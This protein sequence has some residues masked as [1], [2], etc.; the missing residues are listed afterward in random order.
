M[1]DASLAWNT[2]V[3]AR[4]QTKT[5]KSKV[6]LYYFDE[7]AE[8]P[9][10]SESAGYGARHAAELPY[11]FRQLTEHNRPAPTQKDEALSEMLRTFWTNFAKTGDPN[12]TDLPKWPAYSDATPQMLHIE[13][14]NTK[15]GPMINENGLK[16]LDEYFTWRRTDEVTAAPH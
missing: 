12:D 14:G 4:L 1:R 10:G 3:W 15:A 6:F 11:V 16:V 9:A 2:W 5:G 8:I 13:A 7:K